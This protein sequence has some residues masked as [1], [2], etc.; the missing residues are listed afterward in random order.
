PATFLGSVIMLLG[1]LYILAIG[2]YFYIAAGFG[3]GPRDSLML[4][5]T[6]K[7]RLPV[8]VVRSLL[9]FTVAISGWFLGG[10]VGIGT[11]IAVF[12]GGFCIQTSF[13]FF[14][15][16]PTAVKHENVRETLRHFK[17]TQSP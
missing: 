8:G 17:A 3:A 6:R 15:F 10:L 12:G 7:S 14:G 13:R 5:L 9:E 2:S 1:G 16:D 11:I 4:I